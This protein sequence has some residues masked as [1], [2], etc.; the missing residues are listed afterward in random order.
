MTFGLRL[1]EETLEASRVQNKTKLGY[2][3]KRRKI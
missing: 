1:T 2:S 3:T